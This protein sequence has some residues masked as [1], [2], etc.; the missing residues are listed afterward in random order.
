MSD[1]RSAARR[2]QQRRW[3]EL[4]LQWGVFALLMGSWEYLTRKGV[5]DPFFYGQPSGILKQ[6]WEWVVDGTPAGS[7][8]LN[9]AVT[10]EETVLSF[11]I[12]VAVGIVAGFVLA[13]S[14]LASVIFGPY[15]RVLNSIPRIVL[16]PLFIIWLG[17]GI[18]SK[19]L[20]GVTLVFFSVFF[21]VYQGVRE[22]DRNV[23]NNARILGAS[24]RHLIWH[25]QLPSALSWIISSLHTSFG[26]ALV[27]AVVA[28]FLGA[29][30]GIGYLIAMAKGAFDANAVFA[31]MV[32]LSITALLADWLVTM[33]ERRL[34]KWR[35]AAAS[36][37][38]A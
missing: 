31:G 10:L 22:V 23:V 5:L 6:V 9:V 36:E 14:R 38:A 15:I 34:T 13:R 12:G 1:N 16:A 3:I 18:K 35:P 30:K 20:T 33:L 8:W 7:L 11:L 27:G 37:R 19:V 28:E 4:G 26:F 32:I 29:T 21:N 25:V 24:E 2:N 17:L